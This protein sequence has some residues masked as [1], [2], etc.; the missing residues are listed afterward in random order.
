MSDFTIGYMI[1]SLV[2]GLVIVAMRLW[3]SRF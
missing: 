1:G 2:T 3:R